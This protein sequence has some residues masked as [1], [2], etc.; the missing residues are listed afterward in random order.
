[1]SKSAR[2]KNLQTLQNKFSKMPVYVVSGAAGFL[3]SAVCESLLAQNYRVIGIDGENNF[4]QAQQ[5]KLTKLPNFKFLT[6][7]LSD[8][9]PTNLPKVDYVFHLAGV[10]EYLGNDQLSL[11]TLLVN[12]VGTEHLA[13]KALADGAIFILASTIDV[14]YGALSGISLEYYFGPGRNDLARYSHHEAKR[15]AEALLAEYYLA[16][17]L[18]VRICR[19]AQIFGPG[20]NLEPPSIIAKLIKQSV[21]GE[22]LTIAGDGLEV[23]YPTYIG[24]VSYGFIKTALAENAS[25]KI[26]SLVAADG[27]TVKKFAEVLVETANKILAPKKIEILFQ[28]EEVNLKFPV[29]PPDTN[30]AEEILG[31]EPKTDLAQGLSETL[32]FFSKKPDKTAKLGKNY[33]A[34]TQVEKKS[35]APFGFFKKNK[36]Q[37][38]QEKIEKPIETK[39]KSAKT[40]KYLKPLLLITTVFLLI[41]IS[42][43]GKTGL[44]VWLSIRSLKNSYLFFNQHNFNAAASASQQ[45]DSQLS[46]LKQDI[47]FLEK[48][49]FGKVP[50]LYSMD[51]LT[52]AAINISATID[53]LSASG[54]Q[55]S[56]LANEVLK[57]DGQLEK[58]KD[59]LAK[60]ESFLS[61]SIEKLAL[62]AAD[63]TDL[64]SQPTPIK[65]A[66]DKIADLKKQVDSARRSLYQL[67]PI[68]ATAPEFLGFDKEQNY[69]VILQNNLELRATGGFIGSYA[70]ANFSQGHLK[71]LKVDD[72]YNIDGQLKEK[73]TPPEALKK[74]LAV[75]RWYLR[76]SNWDPDLTVAAP[77]ILDFYQK[78]TGQAAD[79]VVAVDVNFIESLLLLTGP[80]N[81]PDFNETITDQNL[82][83][84]AE[85]YAE[86]GFTPGSQN[87]KNF[88]SSL[89][90]Q[91][92]AR[93]LDSTLQ[94]DLAKIGKIAADAANQ[95]HLQFYF[96][97]NQT[98]NL[99]VER[100]WAG[101]LAKLTDPQTNKIT[102][103]YLLVVDSNIGANKAN[104]FV[105]KKINYRPTIRRDGDIN[106]VVEITYK[107][108][109]PAN[110]WPGGN[111]KNYLRIY[112]PA[113][114]VIEKI[115][116]DQNTNPKQIDVSFT[117]DKVVYGFLVEVPV[118][119]EL[120]VTLAYKQALT[121]IQGEGTVNYNL[122]FE[123]QAGTNTEPVEISI[124]YPAYLTPIKYPA[125]AEI[126]TQSI[127]INSNT[128]T[129]R[130]FKIEF[131]KN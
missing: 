72:I 116:N 67:R 122:I 97:N 130:N 124:E 93:L 48:M 79:A 38:G 102:S 46:A 75:E 91:I 98:Q 51:K 9:L 33:F 26:F 59:Q 7:N 103:D 28:K 34:T 58:I 13:K 24:D 106:S 74:H 5:E 20:M 47:Y 92:L 96:K 64:P 117:N 121:V 18:D 60:S 112:T 70:V 107:N 16:R 36:S 82:F 2:N 94:K 25:G 12:S 42:F 37:P 73:I 43:L 65:A 1:M 44:D 29:R 81:L 61:L 101:Q 108:N 80:V 99:V 111:Y 17:K 32:S 30:T 109:S 127:L 19:I 66:N 31:W 87:K 14:Y 3:G 40:G 49:T 21:K 55:L 114:T 76:D 22:N 131:K 104:N 4:A 95:K 77:V 100:K 52:N 123:K 54:L 126:K 89:T 69:L 45:S 68:Y 129:D 78:E 120:K 105:S 113:G 85:Y 15:Y 57:N 115:T 27:I 6:A 53:N 110:T 88:L 84:K 119:K 63:L 39:I 56:A 10:E 128:L 23:I 41:T 62:A 8:G 35:F 118:Q 125:E 86:V 71:N 50:F 83:A 11:E 90:N